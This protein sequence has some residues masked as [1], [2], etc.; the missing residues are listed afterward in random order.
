[1]YDDI[2]E[3]LAIKTKCADVESFCLDR[4]HFCIRRK[5]GTDEQLFPIMESLFDREF[6]DLVI[7]VADKMMEDQGVPRI[8]DKVI[9][10]LVIK[11]PLEQVR[12]IFIDD[13]SVKLRLKDETTETLFE[14][15]EPLTPVYWQ[16]IIRQITRKLT[17]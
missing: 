17:T 10:D 15:T 8:H 12:Q 11:T 14:F 16:L 1:M 13:L 3:G 6:R 9:Q 2:I 5:D 4:S 7:Q